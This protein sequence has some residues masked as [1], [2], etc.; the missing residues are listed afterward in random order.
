M[1]AAPRATAICTA[2]VPTAPAAL[3]ISTVSPRATSSRP[4]PRSAVAAATGSAAA[5]AQ[6]SPA[7]FGATVVTRAYSAYPRRPRSQA[8]RRR[9]RARRSPSPPPRPCRRSRRPA[10]RAAAWGTSAGP[11]RTGSCR[12]LQKMAHRRH[13]GADEPRPAPA[14]EGKA[15]PKAQAER[16]D[17]GQP[18][19]EDHRG[20]RRAEGLRRRKEGERQEAPPA[21]GHRPAWA[22]QGVGGTLARRGSRGGEPLPQAAARE[23]P[24]DLGEG[25]VQKRTRDGYLG[26]LPTRPAFEN[27]PR[28]WVPERTFAWSSVPGSGYTSPRRAVAPSPPRGASRGP[29]AGASRTTR[30]GRRPHPPACTSVGSAQDRVRGVHVAYCR[31]AFLQ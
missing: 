2:S 11:P 9:R 24:A 16:G 25:V 5:A 12:L 31:E 21:G 26:K 6:Y 7:S 15:W 20:R 14:L 8:R 17:R 27:L 19:G 3:W 10:P 22:G 4:S 28:R 13:L 29:G 23:N 1:T 18:I 30:R